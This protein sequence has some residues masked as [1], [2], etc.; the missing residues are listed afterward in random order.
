MK[1]IACNL[2]YDLVEYAVKEEL[3]DPM[4]RTFYCNRLMD[5]L[6]LNDFTPD[7]TAPRKECLEQILGAL[8]DYA[9]ESKIIPDRGIT[10]RD[11]FDTRLMGI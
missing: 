8:C 5:E 11:L 3:I 1:N 6:G 2:I 4:D 7:P 9:I 10:G